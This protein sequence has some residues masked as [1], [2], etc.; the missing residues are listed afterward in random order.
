ME[1]LKVYEN[2]IG[3]VANEMNI[4]AVYENIMEN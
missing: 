3:Y 4:F 1:I 2:M